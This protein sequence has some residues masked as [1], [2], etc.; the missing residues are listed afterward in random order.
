MFNCK[1]FLPLVLFIA[2]NAYA[3]DR[4]DELERQVELLIQEIRA[5]KSERLSASPQ[6]SPKSLSSETPMASQLVNLQTSEFASL[7]SNDQ[8]HVLSRPW[9][10]NFD[11]SGFA[12]VGFYDTGTAGTRDHGGFEIKEASLFIETQVWEGSSFFFEFQLNRLGFDSQRYTRTGEV[13]FRV[14][15]L[16][17]AED[18]VLGF[19]LGRIDVPFGEEYLWQDAIDNPLITNSASYVYATDE[20]MVVYSKFKGIDWTFAVTD[21]LLSRSTEDTSDKAFNLKLSGRPTESIYASVSYMNNGDSSL[22]AMQFGGS[23][24]Q[25]VGAWHDS[26]LGDSTSET[27]SLE[28]AGADLKYQFG[29]DGYQGY[30]TASVGMAKLDDSDPLFSRDFRWFA[31]EPYVQFNNGIYLVARYSEIGTYDDDEGYH[32]AGKTFAGGNESFGYDTKRFRRLGLGL[33]W[34]PNPRV[35]AKL[36]LG[37]DW[38]ELIDASLIDTQNENR[39]FLGLE[40]AVRF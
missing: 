31:V 16:L 27:V 38:F 10:Q 11:F 32:F 17:P 15:D 13:Y 24:G 7:D 34:R 3:N 8:G 1:L 30:V 35:R 28:L 23:F 14:Q 2:S 6:G 4:I 21:G 18:K 9:W 40:I 36:E 33:G 19:K 12:G 25:P 39:N 20:G 5:L 37:K 22:S 29:G 26:T